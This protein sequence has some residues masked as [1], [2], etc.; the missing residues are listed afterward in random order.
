MKARDL[1]KFLEKVDPEALVVVEGSDH[2]YRRAD[3][4]KA[5][6]EACEPNKRNGH[7]AE[8]YGP[9]HASDPGNPVYDVVVIT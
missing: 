2:S 9:E 7:L 1:I 5:K 8:Y 3:A 6:A 4:H